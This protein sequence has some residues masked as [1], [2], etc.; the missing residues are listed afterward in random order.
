[1]FGLQ[2]NTFQVD[3]I[4]LN[5]VCTFVLVLEMLQSLNNP[6]IHRLNPNLAGVNLSL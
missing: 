4:A 1:M 6:E 3:P 5:K 2:V